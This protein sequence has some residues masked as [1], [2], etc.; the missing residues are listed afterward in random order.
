MA[1]NISDLHDTSAEAGVIATLIYHPDY[2]LTENIL[3]DKFFY[4]QENR[5]LFWAIRHLVEQGIT[6][7]LSS[8]S[9]QNIISSHKGIQREAERIGLTNL[10]EYVKMARNAVRGTYQ[11]YRL[12][13]NTVIMYAFRR[14]LYF[15][16]GGISKECFN[17][18]LS[19]DDLNDYVNNGINRMS[20]R[21]IFDSDTV[22]LSDKIDSV[23]QEICEERNED[24]SVGIQSKIPSLNEFFTFGRGELTL[25]AGP[26]GRGKS[27][28]FLAETCNALAKGI[29]VVVFDTELTDKVYLPR[30]LACVSGVPVKT[31]KSG[32][33]TNDEEAQI[34][35]A[36]EWVKHKNLVHQFQPQFNK[37]EIEQI[38]RKWLN[39]GKMDFM[40]YD[41]IKPTERYGAAEISQSLGLMADFLKNI[42]GTMKI[43]V[44]GGLQLNTLTGNVADSM[45][46]ERYADVLMYWKPKSLER[47]QKDGAAC[48]NYMIQVV[49]NRNGSIHDLNDEDDFIDISFRGDYMEIKE[50]KQHKTEFVF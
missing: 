17:M 8:S 20:E 4:N 49:K 9:L 29:P 6:T 12:I 2:L 1:Q 7:E 32:K 39:A 14:E 41:Y 42:S 45:K 21:F 47:Q 22:Q 16:A 23:W 31:I 30:L 38:C 35:K 24:G 27:S 10:Y 46:P 3:K 15:L 5:I 50:A 11:E 13:V 48:G 33:Y 19:L 28:Y 44:L 25:V 43:P 18:D 36:I 34:K 40:V 26:T 37:L